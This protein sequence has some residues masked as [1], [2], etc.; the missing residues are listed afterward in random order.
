M[1]GVIDI[2]S[3]TIRLVTALCRA[4]DFM[5]RNTERRVEIGCPV[6]D[7]AVKDRIHEI[8]DMLWRDNQKARVITAD[9]GYKK[10]G[11]GEE[12]AESFNAQAAQM[13]LAEETGYLPEDRK[14]L[15]LGRVRRARHRW[16]LF[17]KKK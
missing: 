12:T 2:G 1:Y 7:E 11:Q 6:L 8:V 10:I 16:S 9:G 4:A 15:S 5:T 14:A 3:N 17:A 13:N